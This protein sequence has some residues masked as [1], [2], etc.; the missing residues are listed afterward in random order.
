MAFLRDRPNNNVE[1]EAWLRR[2]RTGEECFQKPVLGNLWKLL[3]P[4][5]GSYKPSDSTFKQYFAIAT[6]LN[7]HGLKYA[8]ILFPTVETYGAGVHT[9]KLQYRS[10]AFTRAVSDCVDARAHTF[11]AHMHASHS[12]LAH[13]LSQL[14][15]LGQCVGNGCLDAPIAFDH[16]LAQHLDPGATLAVSKSCVRGPTYFKEQI[17]KC[18]VTFTAPPTFALFS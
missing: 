12:F 5:S 3:Y 9:T 16:I 11:S 10:R 18:Q 6:Y 4:G 17:F 7:E 13:T 14:L 8:S 2:P 1:R 15:E